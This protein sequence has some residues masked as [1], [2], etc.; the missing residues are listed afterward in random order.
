MAMQQNQQAAWRYGGFWSDTINIHEFT[1]NITDREMHDHGREYNDTSIQFLYFTR[2]N[3]QP[4][5]EHKTI[6]GTTTHS[7]IHCTLYTDG[8]IYNTLNLQS[9]PVH[10]S[11][12]PAC[13]LLSVAADRLAA[14]VVTWLL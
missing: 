5:K 6:K 3:T 2:R 8:A 4:C 13:R 10:L 14:G 1:G 7:T 9:G 12:L 11:C